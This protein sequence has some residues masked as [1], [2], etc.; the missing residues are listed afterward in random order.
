M[1]KMKKHNN[2][3]AEKENKNDAPLFGSQIGL[4]SQVYTD[5][6]GP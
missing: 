4:N 5:I 3:I 1:R 2:I 6:I